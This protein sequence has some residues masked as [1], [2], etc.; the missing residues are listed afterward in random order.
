[1]FRNSIVAAGGRA[2]GRD[3]AHVRERGMDAAPA[4]HVGQGERTRSRDY[5]AI[6]GWPPFRSATDTSKAIRRG[7]SLEGRTN[8]YPNRSGPSRRTNPRRDNKY[9][10]TTNMKRYLIHSLFTAACVTGCWDAAIAQVAPATILK[11]DTDN[12]TLYLNDETDLAK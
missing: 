10:G 7:L 3:C 9:E 2:N 8:R 11:I 5:G 12:F 6:R 4:A 1:M